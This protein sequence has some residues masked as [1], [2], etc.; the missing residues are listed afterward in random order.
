MS[1]NSADEYVDQLIEM[2]DEMTL[3]AEVRSLVADGETVAALVDFQGPT[4]TVSYAQWFTLADGKIARLEVI[5]DPRPF[6]EA[7]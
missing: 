6:I 2:G 4:S 5:Y 1:A 3:V 7:S